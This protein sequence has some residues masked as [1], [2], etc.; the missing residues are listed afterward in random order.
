MK[1]DVAKISIL[2]ESTYST[3]INNGYKEK[4]SFYFLNDILIMICLQS[5]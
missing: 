4:D 1:S 5:K 2:Y 3:F